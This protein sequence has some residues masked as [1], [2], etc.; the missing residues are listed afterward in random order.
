[1]RRIHAGFE[2]NLNYIMYL[3][4]GMNQRYWSAG[5]EFAMRFL[6][7]QGATYGEEIGTPTAFKEDR[8]YEGK[9]SF[10]F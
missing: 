10:R 1:M 2:L 6:Q 4:G 3:R 7:I 8:R 5:A 9:I